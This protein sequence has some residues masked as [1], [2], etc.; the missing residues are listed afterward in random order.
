MCTADSLWK[1]C[2]SSIV[3]IFGLQI[4]S[5]SMIVCQHGIWSNQS[6]KNVLSCVPFSTCLAMLTQITR[7]PCREVFF[8]C[9]LTPFCLPRACWYMS[10]WSVFH[11]EWRLFP[12]ITWGFYHW[13]HTFWHRI[14]NRQMS[15]HNIH[16]HRQTET[17]SQ[18]SYNHLF[19]CPWKDSPN[20]FFS[21]AETSTYIVFIQ[22]IN[23]SCV[24]EVSK[25]DVQ[26]GSLAIKITLPMQTKV[27]LPCINQNGEL[28]IVPPFLAF[29]KFWKL[30][31]LV[32]KKWVKLH[33]VCSDTILHFLP[34]YISVSIWK[35]SSASASFRYL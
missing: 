3:F 28:L 12:Q 21:E 11:S 4:C 27:L 10:P 15:E 20:A 1:W 33:K 9:Y 16:K 32:P 30:L 17:H 29:L 13:Q 23:Q 31:H 8:S 26:K 19:Y 22:P 14:K 34:F 7:P 35:A 25:L 24:V 6:S 2:S 5:W 18:T